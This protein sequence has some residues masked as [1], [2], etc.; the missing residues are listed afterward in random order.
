VFSSFE[1]VE[2]FLLLTRVS[3]HQLI[4][5]VEELPEVALL[6]KTLNF[7]HKLGSVRV[8]AAVGHLFK[9]NVNIKIQ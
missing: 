2:S 5:S 3:L 7:G 8:A 9:K 4:E 1:H 6:A